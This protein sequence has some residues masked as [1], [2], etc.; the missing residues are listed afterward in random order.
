MILL[1][2]SA[3]VLSWAYYTLTFSYIWIG[4]TLGLHN[5]IWDMFDFPEQASS[6]PLWTLVLGTVISGLAMTG[7]GFAYQAVWRILKGSPSQDFRLLAANLQR[8]AG[9][10]LGFWLGS[11]FISGGMQYLITFGLNSVQGFDFDWDILDIDII[12][13]ILAIAFFAISRSLERAW[14]AEE[15]NMSY[16]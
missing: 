5:E 8:L 12:F 9:G 7:L 3:M 14:E 4:Q 1:A 10:V 15:E 13:L 6:P 2:K 16:L 11:N